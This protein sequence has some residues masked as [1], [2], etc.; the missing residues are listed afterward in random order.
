M[1]QVEDPSNSV[2]GSRKLLQANGLPEPGVAFT[3]MRYRGIMH[4]SRVGSRLSA[5]NDV[6]MYQYLYGVV[7]R[8]MPASWHTEAVKAQAVAA[9]SYAYPNVR[10]GRILACTTW[11]QV[12]KGHSRLRDDDV[13]M[14]EDSRA[15]TAV[16]ETRNEILKHGSRVVTTYFF[17]QS[18]GHT[19]NNEDVWVAGSPY[20]ELRGVPDTYEH[21]ANPPRSP[22]AVQNMSGLEIASKLRGLSGVPSG[23]STYVTAVD[24]E[25]VASGHVKYAIFHFSDGSSVRI[26]GDRARSRL[27]LDS[28]NFDMQADVPVKVTV[29]FS[30]GSGGVHG[31][32]PRM[33]TYSHNAGQAYSAYGYFKPRR[34]T[35]TDATVRVLAYRYERKPNGQMGYVYKRSYLARVTNPS[36]SAWSKYSASVQ[37]PSEGKWRLRTRYYDDGLTKRTTSAYRYVTVTKPSV[38]FSTGSGGVHGTAP[39][40]STYSHN[41]GQA[42]SA[43]GYFKPRRATNTDATVRVLAYRYERKPNGQMGYVYKRSYLARVTNPSGSAWSKYSA[44]VQLPSEGTWRLRTRYYDDGLTKR[45]TS[46]YR[47]VTVR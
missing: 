5:V 43:Y 18:G 19:A 44:S 15:N 45:T 29:T 33:S 2:D 36:G 46:A 37:L 30:A 10:D 8:E 28:T 13:E 4:L 32:A 14:H 17:S 25:R 16:N 39:R 41:A 21:L 47:Y 7:P 11:D 34:A 35:N 38:T 9:R 3:N 12:Y 31:T 1:I 24:L 23:G 40:M 27:R 20:P 42:Y 26:T 22:W 6:P